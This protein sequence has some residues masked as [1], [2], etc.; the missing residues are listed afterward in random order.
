MDILQ[1]GLEVGMVLK[2]FEIFRR[3][4]ILYCL[5]GFIK[6]MV[7]AKMLVPKF[8]GG[9]KKLTWDLPLLFQRSAAAFFRSRETT[10]R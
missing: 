5:Y 3:D 2:N 7:K 8:T 6:K 4:C 9:N 10:P 1:H